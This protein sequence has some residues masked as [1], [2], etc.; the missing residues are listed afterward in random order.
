MELDMT[1]QSIFIAAQIADAIGVA[2]F[3]L[4]VLTYA[5]L[6]FNKIDAKNIT[7][8]V[9][10]LAAAAMVLVGLMS[11]FN[12]A[13]ALIQVFWISISICAIVVRVRNRQTDVFF[14]RV[15]RIAAE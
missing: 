11:A 1:T 12:L 7:Y 15:R 14:S 4:Y 6:T 5:L 9:M 3:G 13:S 8:F 2:G 10:N